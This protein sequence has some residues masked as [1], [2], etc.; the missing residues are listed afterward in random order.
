MQKKIQ[1]KKSNLDLVGPTIT[2]LLS[3]KLGGLPLQTE[4]SPPTPEG[5]SI[6]T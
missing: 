1:I 4:S 6:I 3:T 5:K 2:S